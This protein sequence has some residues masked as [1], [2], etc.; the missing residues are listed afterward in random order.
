ML[1]GPGAIT[2]VMLYMAEATA[3]SFDIVAVIFILLAVVITMAIAYVFL[4]YGEIIFFRIGRVGAL[5]FTRIM[6]LILAA[7]AV[8]FILTGIINFAISEGL[9]A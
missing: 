6:G 2:T 1:A 9:I 8:Q 5:A 7:M 4:Y 3:D